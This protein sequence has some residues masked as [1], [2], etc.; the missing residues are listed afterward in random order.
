MAGP[1]INFFI[2]L[3]EGFKAAKAVEKAYMIFQAVTL[4]VGVKGYM[5]ARQM[6]SQG[7]S[8]MANKTAAGGKI[9]VVYGT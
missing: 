2:G 7:Q 5:Q 8:I 1:V 3:Y 4:A 9:P 6:M